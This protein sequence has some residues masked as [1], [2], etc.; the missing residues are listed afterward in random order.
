MS[1]DDKHTWH[2]TIRRNADN[3]VRVYDMKLGPWK[4]EGDDYWFSEGNWSCD[5]N[6]MA[7]F[8]SAGA[9]GEPDEVPCGDGAYSIV[10]I[11]QDDDTTVLYSEE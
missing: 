7:G 4:G 8:L 9:E 11:T 1:E 3:V 10:S 2:V 6:R 5:C